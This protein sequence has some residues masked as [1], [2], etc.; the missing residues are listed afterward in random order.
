MRRMNDSRPTWREAREKMA[1]ESPSPSSIHEGWWG[2]WI[3]VCLAGWLALYL[4]VA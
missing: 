3:V 1:A 4:A 2:F